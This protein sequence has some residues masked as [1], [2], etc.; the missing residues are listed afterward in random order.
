M[1]S[2]GAAAEPMSW[3]EGGRRRTIVA[4]RPWRPRQHAP[5]QSPAPASYS[6]RSINASTQPSWLEF[7]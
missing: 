2:H 4:D 3:L 5:S 6:Q 7:G 1:G